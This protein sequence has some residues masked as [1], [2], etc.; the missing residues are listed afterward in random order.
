MTVSSLGDGALPIGDEGLAA[1][2]V[3][4]R[5]TV[6]RWT[7][8][9]Q[10][11]TG[12]TAGEICGRHVT[13]L[14]AGSNGGPGAAP[15]AE[16]AVIPAS[17]RVPLR[18]RPGGTVDTVF[19]ATPMDGPG[20]SLI[21]A[22]SARQVTGREQE[23]ALFDA[24]S[25]NRGI[26]IA[27]HDAD[28]A[29]VQTGATPDGAFG[30]QLLPGSRLGDVAVAE[31]AERV[32]RLLRHVLHTGV[33]IMRNKERLTSRHDP[34]REWVLC[35]SALRLEDEQGRPAGVASVFVD[36]GRPPGPERLT[37]LVRETAERVGDSLD[38]PRTAQELVGVLAPGFADAAAVDLVQAVLVGEEP[39]RWTGDGEGLRGVATAPAGAPWGPR[40]D[41]GDPVL[42]H[43]GYLG[44]R[45]G[46]Y[47][48]AVSLTRDE[49]AAALGARMAD[50][51]FPDGFHSVA[52]APIAA[53]GLVLGAVSAWRVGPSEPF[54]A[55]DAAL[56]QAAAAR[57]ALALDNARRYTHEHRAAGVLQ[58]R[59]LPPSTT[60]T[61]AAETA[62]VYLPAGRGAAVGGDW[63]DA[64]PLPSF[65]LAL[66]A[67][68]VVGH[69]IQAS[70]TM[71]RLRTAIQTLADLELDPEELLTRVGDLVQRL[72]HESEPHSHDVVGA[73]CLYA[74]HDAVT[75]RCTMAS[76]GHPPPVLLRPGKEAEIVDV[77][78]GPPFPVAGAP[79]E[80]ATIGLEPGDVLAL[81]TDGL[82]EQDAQGRLLADLGE[83]TRRL[84]AALTSVYDPDR[85]LAETGRAIIA[86]LGIDA[87]HDDVALMLARARA[88]SEDSMASWDFAADLEAV[89]HAREATARQLADWGLE[90]LAFTTE[91]IVSELVTNAVRHARPPIGLRLIKNG[92]LVCEVCDASPT[93]PRMR[94][95]RTTDEGGRGLFIVAQLSSRWGC[96]YG[97]DGKTI[98]AEQPIPDE[99]EDG[100]PSG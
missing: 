21:L 76:A 20:G 81:Y 74:I 31:D 46:R 14:L 24:V 59:L 36:G 92:V 75:R 56:L 95:A 19:R 47:G 5:G 86:E 55:D 2:V 77:S 64:I 52:V 65:R 62:G 43:P 41:Q 84:A 54:T 80:S 89:A 44:L 87:P 37:D 61:P 22:A 6:L 93:Q 66:V 23:V 90:D 79:Y 26:R 91:L 10:M 63:F 97:R 1:V 96:R 82:I 49:V 39:P 73:T 99:P 69:G 34:R 38:V 33:P 85:P 50:A 12:F 100:I 29:V 7:A 42:R 68:D 25:G 17:G 40:P 88:V 13:E 16:Q 60:D 32:E 70:A 48:E 11:L 51:V 67:G 53:R 71:G 28:L 94:R 45:H 98:W 58:Q 72:A 83:G 15:S 57:G 9:A 35:W 3:D 4:S 18:H 8:T 30:P 27:L 78:Q